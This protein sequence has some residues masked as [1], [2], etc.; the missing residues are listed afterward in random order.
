MEGSLPATINAG[1]TRSFDFTITLSEDWDINHLEIV[2]MLIDNAS[3]KIENATKD[4]AL[5]T[6][7]PQ[8]DANSIV[9]YPNPAI[10]E[11]VISIIDPGDIYIY[12][13]N[14]QLVLEK[15]NVKA[16]TKLD[17]SNFENGTYIVK[18]ISDTNIMTAK[19]NIVK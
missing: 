9:I 13:L 2:G 1:E 6:G 15:Q 8:I 17:I 19:L 5:I 14:G 12:N 10:D 16:A 11:V 18:V 7:V 3:G 4:E